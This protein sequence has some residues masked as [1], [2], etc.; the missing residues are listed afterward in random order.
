M[1]LFIPGNRL[2]SLNGSLALFL[3]ASSSNLRCASCF[4][5]YFRLL[6][7]LGLVGEGDTSFYYL[8]E[9]ELSFPFFLA[10]WYSFSLLSIFSY[11]IDAINKFK[12]SLIISSFTSG[13]SS[14]LAE[15][16]PTLAA[17]IYFTFLKIACLVP[18]S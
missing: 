16:T 4:S 17:Y 10:S 15:P 12:L 3:A 1:I 7:A 5:F 14:K 8:G 18:S 11:L 6:N 13:S 9:G 2:V